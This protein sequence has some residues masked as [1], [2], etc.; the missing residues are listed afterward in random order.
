MTKYEQ[1]EFFG[2]ENRLVKLSEECGELIQALT[3]YYEVL[4]F[5]NRD[6][7]PYIENI[8]E[9]MA[10]VYLLCSE[11]RHLLDIHGHELEQLMEYKIKRTDKVI[12]Q[13]RNKKIDNYVGES[14]IEEL[15]NEMKIGMVDEGRFALELFLNKL[16]VKIG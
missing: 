10:D 7:K 15:I 8:K 1:A 4:H 13:E 6:K 12:E 11:V 16:K 9:E 3:K 2:I 5:A 14:E